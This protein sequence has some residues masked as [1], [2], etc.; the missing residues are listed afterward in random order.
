MIPKKI[1][2]CWFGRGELPPLAQKCIASWKKHCPDYEII[3]WNEDNF[4]TNLNAYTRFCYENKK[5]AFLSDYVRLFVVKEHGGIYF[6]TDVELIKPLDLLLGYDAFFGFE[7]SSFVNTGQGFGCV[8]NHAVIQSML[9]QYDSLKQSSDG[10][11]PLSA[12]PALNTAA[13]LPFGLRQNG[14]HQELDKVLIL[15]TEYMNPFDDSTGT[16]NMTD[17]TISIHWYSKSWLSKGTVLRSKL[18]RPFHRWF[19]T[20]CFKFLKH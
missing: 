5:W 11:F 6:D 3:Q 14:A 10:S 9:S 17:R 19:G 20:D 2:Y 13:L 16:L 18:T 8:A 7:N 4:D 15:P 12:C 1:H